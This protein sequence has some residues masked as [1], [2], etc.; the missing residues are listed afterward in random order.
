M[1]FNAYLMKNAK[2]DDY[3][4][5]SYQVMRGDYRFPTTSSLGGL[6]RYC[7]K[8]KL[9]DHVKSA[10]IQTFEE[11]TELP[12]ATVYHKRDTARKKIGY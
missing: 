7:E 2:K 1:K 6:R 4:R 8:C 3:H 9:S 12:Y 10:L 5:L 11:F